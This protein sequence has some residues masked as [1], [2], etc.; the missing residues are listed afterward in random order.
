MV[1]AD[2]AE[3]ILF[4]NG[5]KD[6]A[7]MLILIN[8]VW[9]SKLHIR[10][11]FDVLRRNASRQTLILTASYWFRA[12]V[13]FIKLG[14]GKYFSENFV[15]V[16]RIVYCLRQTM[17]EKVFHRLLFLLRTKEYLLKRNFRNNGNSSRILMNALMRFKL[18]E[19]DFH[20]HLD[21]GNKFIQK[22]FATI[23][24]KLL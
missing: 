11:I 13:M 14:D 5:T 4:H 21:I 3:I 8:F 16:L 15:Y 12:L 22:L 18:P 9:H 10:N 19:K 2:S 23:V 17:N 6:G 7:L 1:I 20:V 24:L